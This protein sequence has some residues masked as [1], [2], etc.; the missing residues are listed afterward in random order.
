V[1]YIVAAVNIESRITENTRGKSHFVSSNLYHEGNFSLI[2]LWEYK[3]I[4]RVGYVVN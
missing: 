1:I 4:S 2:I 3:A